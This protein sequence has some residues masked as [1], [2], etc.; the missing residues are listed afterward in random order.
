MQ[1]NSAN[2][3][4]TDASL[5][6]QINYVRILG[7]LRRHVGLSRADIARQTGLTRSTVTVITAEL[8]ADELIRE[9]AAM[10]SQPGGGRPGVELELNPEGAFFIGAEIEVDH[11][12]VVELNLA[13]NVTH[14]LC[15]PLTETNPNIVIHQLVQLIEQ[16]RQANPLSHQRL[17]GIGLTIP[18]TLNRDGV[19]IRVPGLNWHGVNLR[20]YLEACIDLPLFID[21][22]ANAAALAEVYLGSAIQRNS[23]LFLLLNEGVGCGIVMNHRIMRGAN[24][25][26]GEICELII[27]A[28][29]PIRN[30]Y[31]QPGS[32]GTL[33]GKAGL[34]L[35]YQQ[36][37]GKTVH[38]ND[39]VDAL[40]QGD[41]IAHSRVS[42]WAQRLGQG[43]INIV[44][45]LNPE[46]I[47]LGGP[48]TILLPYVKDQINQRL[49]S[50]LPGN[51]KFGFFSTPNSGWKIS[52]FG[53][54][55]SVIG[56]AVLV[57]QSLFQI[58]DL[59]SLSL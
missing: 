8:I 1:T 54:N 52:E 15:Q 58:P 29:N 55:A 47:V 2:K 44:N 28:Q 36:Q 24:G 9:G 11:L 6:K 59:V 34:L 22:D 49:A 27:D 10:A 12:K 39:L 48:L 30:E 42:Q 17:R 23:L 46:C 32:L 13:A 57:Y 41:I 33:V 14:I 19:L 16:L 53:E 31:G 45:I 26:A 21:N 37:I 38:L 18:G 20:Q 56:G 50:E 35:Q 4:S 25:T 43:L 7:L 5:L 3:L 51:G 40:N